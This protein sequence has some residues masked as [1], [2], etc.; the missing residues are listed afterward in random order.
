MTGVAGREAREAPAWLAR[1]NTGGLLYGTIVCAAA[2]TLGAGQGET[3]SSLIEAMVSTLLIYWLA[4]V[5]TATVGGRRFGE[6]TT[7]W[8]RIWESARHES[9]IL[10][11][12]LPALLTEISLSLAGVTIWVGVLSSIGVAIVM[13]VADGVLAGIHAGEGGW[14]LGAE[15]VGAAIFGVAIAVLLVYLHSH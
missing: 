2:L 4:H 15:G 10:I 3:E 12:G 5:Y 9:A 13:L 8:H 7:L 14:R 6:A 1:L 11:G